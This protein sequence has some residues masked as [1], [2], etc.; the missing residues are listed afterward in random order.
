M[1][2]RHLAPDHRAIV[3]AQQELLKWCPNVEGVSKKDL[4]YVCWACGG[5]STQRLTRC[6]IEQYLRETAD[7]P[8][9]L[10]IL[11]DRCHREQP[12]AL[13]KEVL[14]YWL[15]TRESETKYYE[16]KMAVC[17]AAFALLP[18]EFGDLVVRVARGDMEHN[19]KSWTERCESWIE[20]YLQT[21]SAGR[22]SGN[23]TANIEWAWFSEIRNSLAVWSFYGG[24]GGSFPVVR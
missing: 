2:K 20:Q 9:N 18:K 10:I 1:P 24:K 15:S 22:G 11:C 14:K 12:D 19:I 16:R 3:N 6:H 13:R 21:K 7:Q 8:S 5:R 4:E 17:N 23:R